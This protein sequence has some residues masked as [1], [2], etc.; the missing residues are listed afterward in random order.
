M[1]FKKRLKPFTAVALSAVVVS[2][3]AAGCSAV[4]D[5]Q[6]AAC[7]TAFKVGTTMKG[8]DFSVD[9]SIQ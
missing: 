8:T 7:C 3:L 4:K 1:I 6:G 9:A 5:V 2:S